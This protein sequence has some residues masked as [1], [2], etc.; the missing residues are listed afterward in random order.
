MSGVSEDQQAELL[1]EA[2]R[3]IPLE[4]QPF[5]TLGERVGLSEQQ[6]I[7]TLAA[8]SEDQRLREISAVLEGEAFGWE[9]ALCAASVP[10]DRIE[11]VA[12][13]VNAHPTVTH[14]YQRDHELN[15]W[16][17]IAVPPE[18]G[19]KRT[20]ELLARE[21][22]VE[23]F[24]PL[25]RTRTFKIGVRF[26]PKTLRNDTA[27]EDRSKIGSLSPND[28][29]R[30]MFRA[31]QR[32]LTFVQRPFAAAAEC[33]DFSE[34]ELIAFAKKHLGGAVRRYVATL[35]HRKMGVRA[36]GMV[37]WKSKPEDE[38]EA[39]ER[40]AEAPEVS[41]CYARGPAP[42]FPYTLYS[43]VHGPDEDSCRQVAKRLSEETGLDDYRVLFSTREFKKCRLRYFLPELD[44]WWCERIDQQRQAETGARA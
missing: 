14:D 17:T 41:H 32:P 20:L 34:D 22:G 29:E 21:A 44:A 35:R 33:E 27:V 36:N 9:S 12:D 1:R 8:L 38:Q 37:V 40:L 24:H 13:V 4:P 6:T 2:Q 28:R 15:L 23:E 5:K 39:G 30:A 42:G 7:E 19:L 3:E 18:M 16:F 11:A 10:E 25:Q 26:D 43:M 31:L